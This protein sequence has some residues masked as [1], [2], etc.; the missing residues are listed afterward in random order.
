MGDALN[1]VNLV[2]HDSKLH[3]FQVYKP[4]FYSIMESCWQ[5]VVVIGTVG[6]G[7]VY[8]V[9]AAGKLITSCIIFLSSILMAIPMTIIIKR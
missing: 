2:S 8:P 4:W 5:A 1:K 7:N 9:Y 6:Y 3:V